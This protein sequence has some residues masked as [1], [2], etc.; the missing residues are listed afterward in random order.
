[1][2]RLL[3]AIVV[4]WAVSAHGIQHHTHVL[5][6]DITDPTSRQTLWE[7][8]NIITGCGVRNMLALMFDLPMGSSEGSDGTQGRLCAGTNGLSE[9]KVVDSTLW[10]FAVGGAKNATCTGAGDPW[11]CCTG[12][13]AGGCETY[14]ADDVILFAQ[15]QKAGATQ[16]Q[17][18]T[19][20]GAAIATPVAWSK[21]LAGRARYLDTGA[22]AHGLRF[23][24]TVPGDTA[25]HDWCEYAIQTSGLTSGQGALGVDVSGT[26]YRSGWQLNHKGISP[27]ITKSSGQILQVT[28]TITWQ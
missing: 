3:T 23:T 10:A 25:N 2:K 19:N 24:V 4:L 21:L 8:S 28:I 26:N 5:I 13:G 12:S 7:G 27:C 22:D 14:T 17:L 9:S 11:P 16:A 20:F 1:M 18:E 6:E 15:G